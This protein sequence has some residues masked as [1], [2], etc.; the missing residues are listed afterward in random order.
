MEDKPHEEVF[1]LLFEAV[2]V[3]VGATGVFHEETRPAWK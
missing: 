1:V 2:R 3:F